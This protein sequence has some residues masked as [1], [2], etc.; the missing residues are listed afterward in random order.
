[1]RNPLDE[2]GK[3]RPTHNA[4]DRV[5]TRKQSSSLGCG[6]L[7]DAA[8]GCRLRWLMSSSCKSVARPALTVNKYYYLYIIRMEWEGAENAEV[9]SLASIAR[10]I[11]HG[12]ITPVGEVFGLV[13]TK[14]I[15][16]G[17]PLVL[18]GYFP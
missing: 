2:I 10:Q 12:P 9:G 18:L 16:G 1:M 11:R 7:K 13:V 17:C 3:G 8:R 14:F 5:G 4:R 6:S 15:K